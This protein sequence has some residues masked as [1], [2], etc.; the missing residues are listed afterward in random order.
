MPSKFEIASKSWQRQTLSKF[1]IGARVKMHMAATD[2]PYIRFSETKIHTNWKGPVG[3]KV[4]E[5][6]VKY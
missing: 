1:E 6:I 4:V 3:K 5:K 2:T